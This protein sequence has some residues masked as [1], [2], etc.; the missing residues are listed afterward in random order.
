MLYA[1]M[2]LLILF[3]HFSER[4]FTVE[5]KVRE[6]LNYILRNI[7]QPIPVDQYSIVQINYV[8]DNEMKKLIKQRTKQTHIHK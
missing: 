7:S 2:N 3:L 1:S 6:K 8:F 5:R 4:G